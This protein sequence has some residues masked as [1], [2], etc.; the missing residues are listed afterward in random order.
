MQ[1]SKGGLVQ[2][3]ILFYFVALDV[4]EQKFQVFEF[5]CS[6]FPFPQTIYPN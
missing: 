3:F 4:M 6:N 5:A 2:F 1:V